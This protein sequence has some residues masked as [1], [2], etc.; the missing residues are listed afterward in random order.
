M[1]LDYSDLFTKAGKAFHA[2]ATANTAVGTT[3]EDE[4]EDYSQEY[5]TTDPVEVRAVI[6]T[7]VP[8]LRGF[9]A[10]AGAL[11]SFLAASVRQLLVE[12]VLADNPQLDRDEQTALDELIRQMLADSESLDA[13][14]VAATPSYAAANTGNGLVVASVRR[15][16][17]KT[18][19]HAYAETLTLV[20]TSAGPNAGFTVT[21]EE[22][23]P[24][25]LA[26]DWPK[27]SGANTGVTALNAASGGNLVTNA[28]FT[29]TDD[30]AAHL[31]ESWIASVATL[32][33]TLKM[34][35]V[36]QQTVVIS[37]TPTSGWYT[38]TFTDSASDAHTTAPLAFNASESAVQTALRALPGLS[39]VTVAT[40]GTTPNFT[41]TIT[42]VDVPNPTQLTSTETFDAGS[43]AHNTTV[44]GSANAF[45]GSRTLEIDSDGSQ[46]TTIQTA[47]A[48]I[49]P[50]TQ[51][52]VNLYAITDSVPA[53]GVITIDLIDGIGGAVIR[54]DEGF[55]NSLHFSAA[56]LTTSH[57]SL[58]ALLT[59]ANEV[60]TLTITGTPTGGTFTVTFDGQT[61]AAIAYNADAA[62]V[63]AALELLST[64]GTG[65]VT[66]G[67]GALPGT[68]VTIT[69]T[70]ALA[71]RDVP[72]A[73][74]DGSGLTGGTTPDA[75]I[76]LTTQGAPDYAVFRTP[77]VLPNQVYL[78]IRTSTAVSNTS[79]VF[80][81]EVVCQPMSQVYPGGVWL[82]AFDGATEWA[83]D[84]RVTCAVTNDRGGVLHEWANRVWN[85]ADS[86]KLIP[87][88]ASGAETRADSLVG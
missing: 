73:T 67:G 44:A 10:G 77:S 51:Y 13:N 12:L 4:V 31:P 15:P 27:G 8:T 87:S 28:R 65:N 24:N 62:T 11:N 18:N 7:L 20:C 57:K 47:L 78:R 2:M 83:V 9:Q 79:S 63:E 23:Q 69:F 48:N 5:L 76:A 40:T 56:D 37:G 58:D 42:F 39:A 74:A 66:C 50:Q 82:A 80:L 30:N 64:I 19:E 3:V 38:L 43:I 46:L 52:A 59:G 35:S 17:G 70:N 86:E 81:N 36:E 26:Y 75:A 34:S 45:K 22:A 25:K 61:T 49:A 21:G 55:Q 29:D 6:D 54:D 33:T 84:D 14:A 53:A 1:A 71:K 88:N 60:Q 72:L 16:D 41:H 68:P 32:G 85:L